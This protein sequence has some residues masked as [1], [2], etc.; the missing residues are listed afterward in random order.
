VHELSIASNI[1]EMASEAAT[2]AGAQRVKSIKLRLGALSGVVKEALLFGFDIATQNTMVSGA[3]LQIEELPVI[4][5]CDVCQQA[6]EL[7]STQSFRCPVC[8]QPSRNIRQGKELE[9]ES[10]EVEV[11]DEP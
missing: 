7:P 1:V 3:T 9:V 8:H 11:K 4:I 10:V 5:F 6:R 2:K